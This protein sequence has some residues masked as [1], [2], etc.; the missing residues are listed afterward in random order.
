MDTTRSRSYRRRALLRLAVRAAAVTASGALLAAH[1]PRRVGAMRVQAQAAAPPPAT[2]TDGPLPPGGVALLPDDPLAVLTLETQ[3]G[4]KATVAQVPVDGQP[5]DR[6][7]RVQT[8]TRT[9]NSYDSKLVADTLQ[10]IANGDTLFM[11]LFARLIDT[12]D[13]GGEGVVQV[14]I[15]KNDPQDPF[16]VFF[17]KR[18]TF[19]EEWQRFD[20]PVPARRG[21]GAGETRL[22]IE[23]GGTGPQVIEIGGIIALNYGTQLAPSQL[24]ATRVTYA[25]REPDAAW[26]NAAAERIEQ[27]RK[28]DLTVWVTDAAGT[29]LP[30]VQVTVTMQRHAYGFGSQVDGRWLLANQGTPDGDRYADVVKTLFNE[31]VPGNELKWIAWTQPDGPQR[32]R[33]IVQWLRDSG[34]RV[35]GHNLVWPGWKR[36]PASVVALQND[37]PALRQRVNEHITEEA[38]AFAGQLVD[39]DVVNEP[40]GNHALMDLLGNDVMVEWYRLAHAADPTARLYLNENGIESGK[41]ADPFARWVEFLLDRGA[42]LGGLGFQGHGS[43]QAIEPLAAIFDRFAQY[44]L[45]IK[46]TEFDIVTPDEELQAEYTRDYLTLVF[47]HPATAGFVMWGF[48]DGKHWLNDAPL[49]YKDWTRKPSGQAWQDLVFKTWWTDVRGQTN[50]QGAYQVRGFLGD[51]T[52]T[53]QACGTTKTVQAT[54]PREGATLAVVMD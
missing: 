38:T 51:Y 20:L 45:P 47:S 29:A 30:G 22:V 14:T 3:A 46:I 52:V 5:F 33:E 16:Q 26:R 43:A 7:L 28:G 8:T 31:A 35:R 19:A 2:P 23:V 10:P 54:L 1:P 44:G 40:V 11:R 53:V 25:G 6:A 9:Q 39:W 41:K 49:Y 13:E 15:Q 27:H 50:A 36:L 37:P 48:W 32:A 12:E 4:G 34:L 42:P 18:F 17:R 24:P 21:F